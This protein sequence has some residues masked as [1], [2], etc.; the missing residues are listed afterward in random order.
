M[1]SPVK[2]KTS[3]TNGLEGGVK[4]IEGKNISRW[5]AQKHGILRQSLT[6]KEKADFLSLHKRLLEEF[7]PTGI[8][9]EMLVERVAILYLKLK[10]VSIAEAEYLKTLLEPRK[11]K[12][13]FTDT[14]K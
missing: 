6:D 13:E 9:E 10:R 3:R 12:T 11:V 2:M 14:F 1:T 8:V 7:C 5:N 4:T